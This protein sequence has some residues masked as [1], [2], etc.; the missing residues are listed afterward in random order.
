[1]VVEEIKVEKEA[2][3]DEEVEQKVAPKVLIKDPTLEQK[4]PTP[5]PKEVTMSPVKEHALKKRKTR[6]KNC[7]MC[8]CFYE[9]FQFRF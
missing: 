4:E 1:M 3:N 2:E 6:S 5:E 9:Q 7:S 8:C